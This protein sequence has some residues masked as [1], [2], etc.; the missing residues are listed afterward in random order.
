M[1]EQY[2]EFF[3]FAEQREIKPYEGRPYNYI[4]EA[5]AQA[6]IAN[7]LVS[8]DEQFRFQFA[9][10]WGRIDLISDAQGDMIFISRCSAIVG[11]FDSNLM[12][13]YLQAACTKKGVCPPSMNLWDC[14][15]NAVED[16]V[17]TV[18]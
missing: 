9:V 3:W 11:A 14:Q 8:C 16:G 13:S 7:L 1:S 12:L 17:D 2:S 15:P 5:S 6:E 18:S 10:V 4:N